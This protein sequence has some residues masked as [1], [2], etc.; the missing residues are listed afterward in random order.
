MLI[1]SCLAGVYRHVAFCCPPP[2]IEVELRCVPF[3]TMANIIVSVLFTLTLALVLFSLRTRVLCE[4]CTH[5]T[6]QKW[7]EPHVWPSLYLRLKNQWPFNVAILISLPCPPGLS[8][9]LFAYTIS[10]A[11]DLCSLNYQGLLWKASGIEQPFKV[12]FL[13]SACVIYTE[14]CECLLSG[15]V[16]LRQHCYSSGLVVNDSQGRVRGEGASVIVKGKV[17]WLFKNM[18]LWTFALQLSVLENIYSF[19]NLL[20]WP[21]MRFSTQRSSMF[22]NRAQDGWFWLISNQKCWFL[23]IWIESSWL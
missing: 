8:S 15:T 11:H 1:H 4:Y 22:R 18:S 10:L 19:W 16:T 17:G 5:V 14:I 21:W 6:A 2:I 23:S 13:A 20:T 7:T 9:F 3:D 12:A